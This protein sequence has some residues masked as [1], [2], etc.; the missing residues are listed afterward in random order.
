MNLKK[1][2]KPDFIIIGAMKCATSTLHDQLAQSSSFFMTTLKEPNFF[3]D[4]EVYK[5]GQQWYS[6]LFDE[7]KEGQLKGE[8]ST[9]YTKLPEYP[10]TINR[11]YAFCP[12]IKLI[13]IMR[14]P[15]DR[16]ISNYIHQWTQRV[17]SCDINKAVFKYPDLINNSR[18][19]M[20]VEPYIE[21]FGYKNILPLFVERI[22]ADPLK[23][24][25]TVYNYLNVLSEP[26]WEKELKSNVSAERLRA[27]AW[28]DAIVNNNIARIIRRTLV[29]QR[30]RNAVKNIWTMKGRP[31]LSEDVLTQVKKIFDQDLKKLGNKLN[32]NLDCKNFNEKVL[33]CNSIKWAE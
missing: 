10:E 13:Y 15:V 25:T 17:I 19:N 26:K 4:D 20:Q 23:E 9:H 7:A 29:P 12:D 27:C 11:I 32:L 28:R 16:M 6:S 5:N 22:K 31:T 33:S 18:Y 21:K 14:H 30:L 3:S 24:L 8:S 1:I 2:N